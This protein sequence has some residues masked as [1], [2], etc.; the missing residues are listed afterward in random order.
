MVVVAAVLRFDDLSARPFHCDEA[1]G[2]RIT[3]KRMEPGGYCFDPLH[4]HGPT[5]GRFAGAWCQARGEH[6]WREMTKGT[7]RMLPAAAGTLL[8]LVPLLGRRRWGDGPMLLAAAMFAASPLLV[9]YSR[10]FIHESLLV[11]FGVL[12]L[13]V[14]L[15]KPKHGLPG[16]LVGL[17][18]ATKES[19]AVS[20]IAWSGAGLL[21]AVEN[22]KA[23]PDRAGL[24][25]LWRQ[26]RVPVLVS[27]LTF[28]VTAGFL[29]TDGFR[30]PQGAVDAV[31]TFFVYKT[32]EGHEKA[33]PYYLQFLLWPK[34]AGGV[35]W[36]ETPVLLLAL[37]AYG[38]TFRRAHR[39]EAWCAVAR[40]LAYAAAGHFLV[41]GLIAYK[42]PW[43]AC[44]PWAH[45][46]LLA[47][48]GAAACAK[49]KP[50]VKLVFAVF[51][52]L[53]LWFQFT[54]TK[55]ATGRLASD[56]RNPYA[57]VPTRRDIEAVEQ[58]LSEL[59][60]AG[61][62]PPVIRVEPLGVVG[63]G[64]WPLPWYLRSFEEVG[65]FPVPTGDLVR[66]PLVFAVPDS[67]DAVMAELGTSHTPVPRGLREDVPVTLFL[68]NDLWDRWMNRDEAGKR[69]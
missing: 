54:R 19:F 29:Y 9:Y 47:G 37:V 63:A 64:Y 41:Y 15:E 33:F 7:L 38:A 48:F 5:L 66:F 55:F 40:F 20:V 57:Y 22:R 1:T 46:C 59:R 32:T 10:M 26:W 58:W 24:A 44:L 35:W 27:A 62:Q 25:C 3:A 14:L 60:K 12:A 49:S 39:G 67:L 28:L 31:R 23:W 18:F 36:F 43:L 50:R 52:G 4:F 45:V 61:E 68:R 16:I 2:A 34:K 53:S 11:L 30:H 17:M 6:G 56:A 42:T 69:K 13:F 8:V 65:Y 51:V 21:L